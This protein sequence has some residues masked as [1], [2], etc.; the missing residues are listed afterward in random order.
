MQF[1]PKETKV[2]FEL[3]TKLMQSRAMINRAE[4]SRGTPDYFLDFRNSSRNFRALCM[5]NGSLKWAEILCAYISNLL[6]KFLFYNHVTNRTLLYNK[7]VAWKSWL[8]EKVATLLLTHWRFLVHHLSDMNLPG[9]L[10]L[11]EGLK[12]GL[13]RYG[14]HKQNIFQKATISWSL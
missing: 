7:F 4:P 9:W 3:Y 1:Y 8:H 11:K 6:Q 12:A 2:L 5:P 14:L 10:N 13:L